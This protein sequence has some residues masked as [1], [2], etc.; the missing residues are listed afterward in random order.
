[1]PERCQKHKKNWTEK[2]LG[3]ETSPRTSEQISH[4]DPGAN[5]EGLPRAKKSK[6]CQENKYTHRTI[7]KDARNT[8]KPD[9]NEFGCTQGHPEGRTKLAILGPRG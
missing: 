6:L 2:I 4:F 5:F 7:P 9:I 1:M 8:K 3:V